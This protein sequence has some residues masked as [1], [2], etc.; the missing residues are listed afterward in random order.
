[1]ADHVTTP[2]SQWVLKKVVPSQCQGSTWSQKSNPGNEHMTPPSMPL[3]PSSTVWPPVSSP[4]TSGTKGGGP[5][6]GLGGRTLGQGGRGRQWAIKQNP[7]PDSWEWPLFLYQLSG[8]KS[9]V[10]APAQSQACPIR[11][12]LPLMLRSQWSDPSFLPFSFLA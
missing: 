10:Q 5:G 6:E 4:P 1:M 8:W 3:S 9:V 7:S 11:V 2:S 12:M